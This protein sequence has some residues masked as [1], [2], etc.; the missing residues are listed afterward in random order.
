VFSN[1]YQAAVDQPQ[2]FFRRRG[3]QEA[4]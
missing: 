1:T 2:P 4:A 3:A